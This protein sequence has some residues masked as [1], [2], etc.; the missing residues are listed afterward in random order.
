MKREVDID[1]D[2]DTGLDLPADYQQESRG[3]GDFE[4]ELAS[5]IGTAVV[6]EAVPNDGRGK[7]IEDSDAAA[8]A[9]KYKTWLERYPGFD[10][11]FAKTGTSDQYNRLRR[12]HTIE[13]SKCFVDALRRNQ[14]EFLTRCLRK[15]QTNLGFC[16]KSNWS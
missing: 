2:V 12:I 6:S 11:A 5:N 15:S 16:S 8:L 14:W 13:I 9:A 3:Y 4:T 7:Y 10:R 1:L